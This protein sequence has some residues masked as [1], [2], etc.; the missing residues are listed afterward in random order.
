MIR[1]LWNNPAR[2]V[3][4]DTPVIAAPPE[5]MTDALCAQ[6]GGYGWDTL[7]TEQQ[8]EACQPCHVKAECG[9]FGVEHLMVTEKAGTTVYGGLTPAE[10]VERARAQRRGEVE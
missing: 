6:I 7:S 8:V 3:I 5:W 4:E 9:R 1:A 2:I 10:I